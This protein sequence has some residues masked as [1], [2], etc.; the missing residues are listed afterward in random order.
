MH[1][2]MYELV[3]QQIRRQPDRIESL[4]NLLNISRQLERIADHAVN[5]AEDV[6]YMAKGEIFRHGHAWSPSEPDPADSTGL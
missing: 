1:R 5:I 2:R 3:E 4:I 6:L